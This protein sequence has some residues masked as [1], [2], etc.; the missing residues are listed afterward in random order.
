MWPVSKIIRFLHC[1]SHLMNKMTYIQSLRY[2]LPTILSP[3]SVFNRII[4]IFEL[5]PPGADASTQLDN[6]IFMSFKILAVR[7]FNIYV[8]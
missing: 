3:A 4:C 6:S 7:Q 1:I 8:F 5:A 2:D